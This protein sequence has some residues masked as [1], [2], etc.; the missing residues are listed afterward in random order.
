MFRKINRKNKLNKQK[1]IQ[2]LKTL[3]AVHT[4]THTHTIYCLLVNKEN[5]KNKCYINMDRTLQNYRISGLFLCML[6]RKFNRKNIE[7]NPLE[8]LYKKQT[9]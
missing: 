2:S 9:I 1:R 4:H 6:I 5:E 7:K 3:A 8:I